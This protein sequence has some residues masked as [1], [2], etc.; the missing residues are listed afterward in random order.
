MSGFTLRN[1]SGKSSGF[2]DNIQKNIRYLSIAGLR[3]DDKVIKQSKSV[4]IIEAND[5]SLY[6]LWNQGT[7]ISGSDIGNKE[8][9]AFYDEEYS[10]RRDFLRR[11]S[12]NGEVEHVLETI[13]DET[14]VYDE[15]NFFAYPNTKHL[16]T[17][18]KQDKAKEIV[19]DLNESFKKIYYAFGFNNGHDAWHY[20]K[21]L[22]IDG[23]LSFEIIYDGEGTDDAKNVIGFKELD[24]TSL[25]PE[26]RKDDDE[27]EYRVWVQYRGDNEKQRELLD[28]NLIYISWAR[29]GFIA[30]L[31]Y[32]E[33][34]V[35]S[36]NM[37]R[38]MENS[39]IIWNVMNSQYRM[40]ILVPIG[41]QSEVK[42]R[43][44]LSELRGMY[45]ED[46]TI[47][48]AS[49]EML[50]NGQPN[51][52]FAKTYII[53]T[54]AG[55][56]TEISSFAPDGYDLSNT[57]ALKYFWKR[58]I[59]ETKVPNNRFSIGGEGGEANWT[60]G[61]D[62]ISREEMSFSYFI[63]RARS[64]F[65]EILLKPTWI[66]FCLKRK[67]FIKDNSLKGA[68]GLIYNEE[69]LF[70]TAKEREI[71]KKGAETVTTLMGV[72]QPT[73]MQ[74]GTAGEE[75]Y[76]DPKFLVEKYMD[77]TD[78]DIKLNEKYKK[79][80]AAEMRRLS[81]YYKRLAAMEG[82]ESGGT[83]E[84]GGSFSDMG[85]GGGGGGEAASEE[86]AAPEANPAEGGAETF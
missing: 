26:M 53:P 45:K 55:E 22:L 62:T 2:L 75:Y 27:N 70:K 14:I 48:N 43:T 73:I 56:Q 6:D 68:I 86:T 50:V 83:P 7:T 29:S 24:P 80:R 12:L 9:I 58:F 42:A 72:K 64:V 23:F 66:Q 52:S 3:V 67:E 11:F 16:K 1:I 34:L 74:D 51:F 40:K 39:R 31:S 84:T 17:L 15:N 63:N 36:F 37:L 71:A 81:A 21:K 4:G 44:R 18:L 65:Q 79:E 38:T 76:F 10:S 85:F 20:L 49:G 35:R 41:T 47:N 60:P 30:R 78:S 82:G 33:R 69:N 54:K 13:A 57:D 19:D 32:V 46:I 59:V 8:Y 77:Y 61:S 25:E 5:N 28:A